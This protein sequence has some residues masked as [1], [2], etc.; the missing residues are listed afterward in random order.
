MCFVKFIQKIKGQVL[1]PNFLEKA[2]MLLWNPTCRCLR[3]GTV[4][5]RCVLFPV[6][7]DPVGLTPLLLRNGFGI[8]VHTES[9]QFFETARCPQTPYIWVCLSPHFKYTPVNQRG[10]D[11]ILPNLLTVNCLLRMRA[12]SAQNSTDF[13]ESAQ[14]VFL[15]CYNCSRS[16]EKEGGYGPRDSGQTVAAR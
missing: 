5:P 13:A 2:L 12:D 4:F 10:K 11:T 15:E 9:P 8:A 16:R 7:Q 6:T 1:H 14:V 3:A